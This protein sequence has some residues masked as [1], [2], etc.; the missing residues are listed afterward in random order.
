MLVL[1]AS[2]RAAEQVLG[3]LPNAKGLSAYGGWVAFSSPVGPSA[4]SLRTWHAGT[5]ADVEVPVASAPFDVNVGPDASGRPTAVYSRC[6]TKPADSPPVGCDL[7]AVTLGGT[8][9]RRLPVSSARHS[10]FAPAIWG[11]R[12]A[13]G[14]RVPGQRKADV[15]L[16]RGRKLRRLGPGTLSTCRELACDEEPSTAWPLVMD[17]GPHALAYLWTLS[18]GDVYGAGPGRE[19]RIARLD[20]RRAR[21]AESGYFGGACDFAE[22]ISPNVIGATA[23]YGYS[24]GDACVIGGQRNVFRRFSFKRARRAEASP[25]M[26]G[27]LLSVTWDGPTVYWLRRNYPT[28]QCGLPDVHCMTELVRSQSP[29][30]SAI[31]GGEAEPPLF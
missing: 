14:R 26:V 24:S 27:N 19:L 1:A 9:E 20:R 23:F 28:T 3:P 2:A 8:G 6:R 30:F 12:L 21:N 29:P 4:W 31:R 10:E 16:A 13:F 22:P 25:P 17:L 18:G 11:H 5:V 7:F 15:M